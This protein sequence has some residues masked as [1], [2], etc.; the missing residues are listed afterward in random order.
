M[1]F[2]YTINERRLMAVINSGSN[3][4]LIPVILLTYKK[5]NIYSLFLA[6]FSMITSIFYH[7]CESLK[8]II[9]LPNLKWHELDNIGAICSLNTLI[10]VLSSYF[11]KIETQN[12]L[13]Y[14]STFIVLI[15]QQRGPWYI[16][17]T[18]YPIFIFFII[19]AYDI[20]K[21]GFPKFNKNAMKYGGINMF[22]AIIMYIKGLDDANDYLR[23]Y[24]ALWHV[25]I[26]LS[27]FYLYQLQEKECLYLNNVIKDFFNK[28]KGKNYLKEKIIK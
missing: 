18:L 4:F 23:I 28:F 2:K 6:F 9:F 13:N 24:H 5:N 14:F 17:N 8:V 3:L 21:N 16:Q 12:K 20:F 19:V 25:F 27:S 22:F 26:G 1:A 15:W 7:I 11:P 10:L